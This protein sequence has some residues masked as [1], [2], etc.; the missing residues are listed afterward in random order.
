MDRR[1]PLNSGTMISKIVETISNDLVNS[2]AQTGGFNRGDSNISSKTIFKGKLSKEIRRVT[3]WSILE[4]NSAGQT[5]SFINNGEEGKFIR[6]P[7]QDLNDG[8]DYS[9]V[10]ANYNL[11]FILKMFFLSLA[12]EPV[13]SH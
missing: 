13:R 2:N 6:F 11:T 8:G 3:S 10:F 4:K 5:N 1:P 12:V 9:I 7:R